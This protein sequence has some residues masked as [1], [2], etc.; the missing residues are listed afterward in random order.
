MSRAPSTGWIAGGALVAIVLIQLVPYGRAHHNPPQ[1]GGVGWVS[2]ATETLARRACY[3]C[4]S[5]E[6]RWPWYASVAP[7]SWRIQT[8]VD[9]GRS[10]LNFS[11]MDLAQERA[12]ESARTVRDGTMPPSDYVFMHPRARLTLR[13][14]QALIEGLV[15]TFGDSPQR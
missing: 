3:D 9:R 11:R 8:H 5:H 13:E 15:A 10:K 14:R 6:T 1:V 4:H 2:P 12:R 7:L